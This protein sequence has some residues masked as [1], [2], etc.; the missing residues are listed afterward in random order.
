MLCTVDKNIYPKAGETSADGFSI[1]S[2]VC[3]SHLK[4]DSDASDKYGEDLYGKSFTAKGY[5]LPTA[6]RLIQF[7]LTGTWKEDRY[8][9]F[10]QVD[11][12]TEKIEENRTGIINYLTCGLIKG[13]GF[14]TANLIYKEFGNDTLKV[15][16][17]DPQQLLKIPGIKQKK[18]EQIITSY[19]AYRGAKDVVRVLSPLGIN[20]KKAVKIYNRYL[21][22]AAE[23]CQN[24]PFRL[25]FNHMLSFNVADNLSR[26]YNLPEDAPDRCKAAMLTEL[27]KGENRGHLALLYQEWMQRSLNLLDSRKVNYDLLQKMAQEMTKEKRIKISQHPVTGEYFVYRYEAALAEFETAKFIVNLVE[28]E[29]TLSFD[30][31]D[32]IRKMELDENI[33]L[34][35]EQRNA[36]ITGLRNHLSIITGGPGTGK[37]ATSLVVK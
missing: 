36:V 21:D 7:E 34:A 31:D 37:S 2:F 26:A 10:Y 24:T 29:K 22:K 23:I 9:R 19:T 1:V 3:N 20:P 18:L 12:I 28:K 4:D 17:N 27:R 32:E 30:L 25:C 16:D 14:K 35:P 33:C 15:M 5:Y 13:L 8:G 11:T 6:T